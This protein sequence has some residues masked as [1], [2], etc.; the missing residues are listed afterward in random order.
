[1]NVML[2]LSTYTN[3]CSFLECRS[4]L[5]HRA[6]IEYY[7]KTKIKAANT[8]RDLVDR[9][10]QLSRLSRVRSSQLTSHNELH[11]QKLILYKK[12]R[13]KEQALQRTQKRQNII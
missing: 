7:K 6:K 10:V 2:P 12:L 3:F 11:N 13:L 4:V 8:I 9:N 5:K 1:M